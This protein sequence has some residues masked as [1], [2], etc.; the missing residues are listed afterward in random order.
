MNYQDLSN[1]KQWHVATNKIKFQLKQLPFSLLKTSSSSSDQSDI[2]R[3]EYE[4]INNHCKRET[5]NLPI[6]IRVERERKNKEGGEEM[7][8]SSFF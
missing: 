7:N 2:K 5:I 6:I 8:V 1:K 4:E 3:M